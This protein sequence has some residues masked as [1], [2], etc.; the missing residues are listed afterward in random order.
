LGETVNIEMQFDSLEFLVF[1]P[2]AFM[3]YWL[4]PSARWRNVT[5]IVASYLFYAYADARFT[6]LLAALSLMAYLAGRHILSGGRHK[7]AM[8]SAAVMACLLVL[9]VFKYFNFFAD[10]FVSLVN[11]FGMRTDSVAVHLLLPAGLSFYVFMAISYV[12]DCSRGKIERCPSVIDFLAYI[13]FFPHLLAGPIDRARLLLPQLKEKRTFSFEMGC[14]GLRQILAGLFKKAVIADN[15]ATFVGGVWADIGSQSSATLVFCAIIYSIEIYCDFSGYSDMAIG[16][17]KLFG[18]RLM[19]NFDYPYFSR[20]VTEFWRKWHISL[21]SWF[22]EYL[23]IPLGGNRKGRMRT[24]ANTL[25]VFTLCGLWHGANWTFVAWGFLCGAMFI[26]IL[27][28][29]HPRKYKDEPLRMNFSTAVKMALTFTAI[30]FSWIF[31]RAENMEQAFQFI[32]CIFTNTD[33]A[34]G[35]PAGLRKIVL[36]CV[37][38]VVV[39]EWFGRKDDYM[40]QGIARWMRPIRWCVYLLM[41]YIIFKMQVTG[42]EFIYQNF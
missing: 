39:A 26:P 31:F 21:T 29:K 28:Q 30:T 10:S 35:F 6:L 2:L 7:K 42:G 23:Y 27:L 22:T 20:N 5:L 36:L 38:A 13:S 24:V 15:C 12:V 4:M 11:A 16:I 33:V 32:A 14:D 19:K 3:A 40:L 41:I 1:L 25:I 37:A 34:F 9:G 8:L 17:G 18:I